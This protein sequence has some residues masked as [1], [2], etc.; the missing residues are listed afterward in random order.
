MNDSLPFRPGGGPG[1]ANTCPNG[2]GGCVG[3]VNGVFGPLPTPGPDADGCPGSKNGE[4]DRRVF[5]DGAAAGG[6][7]MG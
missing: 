4:L 3:C 6:G 5:A 2:G 1:A 7:V